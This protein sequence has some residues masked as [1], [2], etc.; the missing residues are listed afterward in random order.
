[1]KKLRIVLAAQLFIFIAWGGWLLSSKN[2]AAGEFYLET[3]PVDPRDLLSGTFVALN[4]DITNPQAGSCEEALK[5]G[6]WSTFYVK[7]EGRGRTARTAQGEVTVYEAVDCA[8]TAPED[9]LWAKASAYGGF[10]GR[11]SARYGIERFYLN[12]NNPLKDAR[13]GSVVAKVKID[14]SR[15]LVLIDL[16]K[17]SQ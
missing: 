10:N 4:Y 1:M 12:E 5:T 8:R 17:K 15:Q 9:G 14:R 7:L 16:V 11:S 6:T 13:S 2:T 3:Q